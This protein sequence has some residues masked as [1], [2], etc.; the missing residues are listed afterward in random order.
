MATTRK[1]RFELAL[2]EKLRSIH[3]DNMGRVIKKSFRQE[4]V[5]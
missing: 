3:R 2:N 5:Y 1:G 4:E